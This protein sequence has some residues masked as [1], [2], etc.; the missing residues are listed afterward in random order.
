[1]SGNVFDK[2]RDS[3]RDFIRSYRRNRERFGIWWIIF[4]SSM[5]SLVAIFILFAVIAAIWFL[6]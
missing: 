5:L 4:V 1:L 2:V 6:P 3:F